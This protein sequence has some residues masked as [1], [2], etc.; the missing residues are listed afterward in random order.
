MPLPKDPIKNKLWRERQ[1]K[2]QKGISRN[3]GRKLSDEHKKNIKK[4]KTGKKYPKLSL[5]KK[6]K[7]PPCVF[8]RRSYK[9]KNNP[10]YGKKH[11]KETIEKAK[12]DPRTRHYGKNHWNWKGGIGAHTRKFYKSDG[13]YTWRF[14]VYERD[15]FIC[16]YCG[17]DKGKC[18]NA[19]HLISVSTCLKNN[20]L[21][22]IFL[23][24]NGITLCENCHKKIHKGTI[25]PKKEWIASIK[26]KNIFYK[27]N[28]KKYI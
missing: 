18:L 23:V 20:W 5:A 19:H 16:Q 24:E 12:K 11:T 7:I 27:N 10:F 15:N 4:A 25:S 13:Y 14:K 6:G 1:S 9:G 2:A 22:L 21:E 17:Y 28:I 26:H 8:T 3:K